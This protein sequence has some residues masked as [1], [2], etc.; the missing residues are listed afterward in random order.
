MDKL[1]LSAAGNE[2][3]INEDADTILILFLLS[4]TQNYMFLQQL[5]Q[6]ETIRNYQNFL[7][8]DLKDQFIM[9]NIKQKVIIKI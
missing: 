8:K 4:K 2:N 7:A 5:Y 1:I 3:N 9:M 6:Q